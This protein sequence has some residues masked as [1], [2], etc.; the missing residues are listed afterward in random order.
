MTTTTTTLTTIKPS[1]EQSGKLNVL[2]CN[3]EGS[4]LTLTDAAQF[5]ALKQKFRVERFEMRKEFESGDIQVAV[6]LRKYKR[7][8]RFASLAEF[9][10]K[11]D[12]MLYNKGIVTE[13][14]EL[15]AFIGYVESHADELAGKPYHTTLGWNTDL[16][17]WLGQADGF[18]P[19]FYLSDV[20]T[21]DGVMASAYQ[22]SL[23]DS[24][25]NPIMKKGTLEALS[26]GLDELVLP[27]PKITAVLLAG[28]AGLVNQY[29][30]TLG[31]NLVVNIV[32]PSST[33][34][35]TTTWMALSAWGN[36][37]LL[38]SSWDATMPGHQKALADRV[39]LPYVIDDA[40]VGLTGSADDRA[41][42]MRKLV[43]KLADIKTK[44]LKIEEKRF[45]YCTTLMSTEISIFRLMRNLDTNGQLYRLIEI[46]GSEGMTK[47]ADHAKKLHQLA[48]DNYGLLAPEL[49]NY[50]LKK[51]FTPEDLLVRLREL[52][53]EVLQAKELAGADRIA[54]RIAL[55]LLTGELFRDALGVNIDL[56]AVKEVLS[57]GFRKGRTLT[58]LKTDKR[59]EL[60]TLYEMRPELF[61]TPDKYD[62]SIHIGLIIE[63]PYCRAEIAF[64]PTRMTALLNGYSAETLLGLDGG[65]DTVSYLSDAEQQKILQYWKECG[66]LHAENS[67]KGL[68][69]RVKVSS[70]MVK[71]KVDE[72]DEGKSR[73]GRL[74]V[75]ALYL[76]ETAEPLKEAA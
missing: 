59:K 43:F 41:A 56:E 13:E 42:A 38:E 64:V 16:D 45:F 75:Y 11:F 53:R 2:S 30:G 19:N 1:V 3:P 66:D 70:T 62:P 58:T 71:E 55:V 69:R 51:G 35:S 73:D 72:D 27:Y 37:L 54:E 6:T 7:P 44:A 5:E 18:R 23:A 24:R 48:A 67:R 9:S 17:E 50:I 32:G 25:R 20:C 60:Y 49:A 4:I 14:S 8:L 52:E 39:V 33:G 61:G 15:E 40:L 47:D 26:A 57:A 22:G 63:K 12:K 10:E 74:T 29:I 21:A 36:P 65:T 76:P 46:D 68:F 28:L 31:Y 34:K